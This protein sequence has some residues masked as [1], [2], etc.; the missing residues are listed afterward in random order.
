ML[1]PYA[2][3][4]PCMV[5]YKIW[6]HNCTHTHTHTH[7]QCIYMAILVGNVWQIWS[8]HV[9]DIYKYGQPYK[10]QEHGGLR[11]WPVKSIP[12]SASLT[13]SGDSN[14]FNGIPNHTRKLLE[15]TKLSDHT[16][17]SVRYSKITLQSKHT[18]LGLASTIH[19]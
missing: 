12:S 17:V 1:L 10:L 18:Y 15:G 7:I 3:G 13:P 2:T 16:S 6:L 19:L 4:S 14:T 5:M 9:F 11:N 8:E